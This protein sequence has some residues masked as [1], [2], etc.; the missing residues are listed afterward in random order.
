MDGTLLDGEGRVPSGLAEVVARLRE[1]GIVFC[2]ASGRQLA[3]LRHTLGELVADTAIIAENG[4]IVV[5]GDRELFRDTITRQQAVT[6]IQTVRQLAGPGH[7]L[8][9][10]AVV[11]TPQVAYVER[12]DESFLAEVDTYYASR[13][14]VADLTALSLD[15][16]L[17]VAVHDFVDAE[18]L[19]APHLA[20][21]APQLQTV[22]SGLHWTDLMSAKASKGRALAI[23]Q[24]RLGVT[25]AQ[26]A[27]FGDYLN[28]VELFD[29][30]EMTFAMANAHSDVLAAARFQA[31]AN[32]EQGVLRVLEE[33]L[34]AEA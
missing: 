15:D 14:V 11:A 9:V 4:T 32:T 16:V 33:L 3:N 22:V 7:G 27:V 31:P 29:E 18:R 25:P 30:A 2:P 19:S 6:V 10:G 20:A 28:D 34:R 5:D 24:Q 17:K 12:T 8:D 26:T 23:L 13:Q 1:R 21:A